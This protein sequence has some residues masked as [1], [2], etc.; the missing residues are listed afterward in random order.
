M[1]N[2]LQC[3]YKGIKTPP[4]YTCCAQVVIVVKN[5]VLSQQ[6]GYHDREVSL[7]KEAITLTNKLRVEQGTQAG[8]LHNY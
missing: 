6:G 1:F 2:T 4:F 8:Y 3:S 7:C 5:L